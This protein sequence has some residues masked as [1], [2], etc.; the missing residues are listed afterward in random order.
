MIQLGKK[1][2]LLG[3]VSGL[4]GLGRLCLEDLAVGMEC[5]TAGAGRSAWSMRRILTVHFLVSFSV[6]RW[7]SLSSLGLNAS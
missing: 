3:E 1:L 5:D 7:S 6:N 4:R 2:T